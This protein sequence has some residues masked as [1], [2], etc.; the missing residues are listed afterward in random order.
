M[1]DWGKDSSF[2]PPPNLARATVE[3]LI[4]PLRADVRR[5]LLA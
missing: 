2:E 4:C 3:A 1:E 5:P